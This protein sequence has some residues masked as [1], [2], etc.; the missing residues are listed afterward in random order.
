MAGVI[1]VDPWRPADSPDR[2]FGVFEI[3]PPATQ[4]PSVVGASNSQCI[5]QFAGAISQF[6]RIWRFAPPP[7]HQ[8]DT[9]YRLDRSNQ[10]CVRFA[11]GGSPQGQC[12]A[13]SE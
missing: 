2:K 4:T 5:S 3:S 7:S 11:I 10:Y 1:D 12:P 6:T 9:S 8:I 13:R